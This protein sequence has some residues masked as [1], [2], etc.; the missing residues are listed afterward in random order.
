M[1]LKDLLRILILFVIT[2]ACDTDTVVPDEERVGY[3]FYPLKVGSY[4]VYQVEN[5][6]YEVTGEVLVSSYQLKTAVVDSFRN[7]AGTISYVIHYSERSSV[8]EPWQFTKAWTARKDNR[9]VTLVE[10]NIPFLKLSFPIKA[11]KVWDGNAFNVLERDNYQMDSSLNAT[12]ITSAQDTIAHTLTVIQE[13]N[14]DFISQQDRRVEVYA[15]NIGLVYREDIMLNYCTDNSCL[16]QQVVESGHE[17]R[18]FLIY[19]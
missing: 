12:F 14:Q 8:D 3:D 7:Q 17:Y 9:Q 4:N 18:Q 11:G 15:R 16:G 5:I 2:T 1:H 6:E 19:D 10:E 13:D